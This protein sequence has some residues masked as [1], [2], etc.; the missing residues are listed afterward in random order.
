MKNIIIPK[1]KHN[2]SLLKI[3]SLLKEKLPTIEIIHYWIENEFK[4]HRLQLSS[5]HERLHIK[6]HMGKM[7]SI[8]DNVTLKNGKAWEITLPKE[9]SICDFIYES[10]F[11]QDGKR[12]AV[13]L[14]TFIGISPEK[15]RSML[16][17]YR[18]KVKRLALS[19]TCDVKN[20]EMS[21]HT[22]ATHFSINT[23][24]CE[25]ASLRYFKQCLTTDDFFSSG[26]KLLS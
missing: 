20:G 23:G 18:K 14:K 19:L 13:P 24:L 1:E 10:I 5:Q 7:L 25:K 4:T 12:P 6:I 8:P 26:Y 22:A 17:E 15:E 21:Y 2:H 9:Y 3:Q 11:R 16:N